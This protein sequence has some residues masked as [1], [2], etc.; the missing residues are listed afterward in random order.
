MAWNSQVEGETLNDQTRRKWDEAV[1]GPSGRPTPRY[2][3]TDNNDHYRKRLM[4]AARPLVSEELQKVRTQDLY[5]STLEH[6]EQQY[7]E[8]A[9]AEAQRPT[10]IPD[11]TLKEVTKYDQ[12]GRPFYEYFGSPRAWIDT[13]AGPKKRLIGIRD[14]R[15]WQKV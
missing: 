13:F 4:D 7:F 5:G 9:K 10:N 6:F 2:L 11:G 3:D 15:N 1:F 14:D 12:S 8:S